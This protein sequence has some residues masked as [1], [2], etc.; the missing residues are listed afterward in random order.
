M[1]SYIETHFWLGLGKIALINIVL[2]VDNAIVVALVARTLPPA[3]QKP[4]VMYGV[5]AI[6]LL[7]IALTLAAV[8]LLQLPYLRII[9]AVALIWIA[10][11]LLIPDDDHRTV[12]RAYGLLRAI[13][14]ILMADLIMSMDNVISVAAAAMGDSMQVILGLAISIPLVIFGAT[15]LMRVMEKW[16]VIITLGAA[17]LGW[18]AGEMLMADPAWTQEIKTHL[19]WAHIHVL[20]W[21]VS[22]AQIIGAIMVVVV[23]KYLAKKAEASAE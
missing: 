8:E 1:E 16:P 19:P 7:R 23:G 21:E 22:W 18:V 20:G 3:Q 4:A 13:R 2:S 5:A 11:K 14:T 10:I 9:G 17:L 15:K 6:V 12:Q